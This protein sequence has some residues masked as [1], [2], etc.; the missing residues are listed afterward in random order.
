MVLIDR[1]FLLSDQLI[2]TP[3]VA[4]EKLLLTFLKRNISSVHVDPQGT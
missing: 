2:R 3:V 4:D 1:G